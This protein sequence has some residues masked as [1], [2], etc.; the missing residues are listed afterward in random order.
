MYNRFK[1]EG[2]QVTLKMYVDIGT[3]NSTSFT[4]T[5]PI[6]TTVGP[7]VGFIDSY[8]GT[9]TPGMLI[10]NSGTTTINVYSDFGGIG[11]TASGSKG[12]QTGTISYEI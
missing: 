1:I 7:A 9:A 11:W 2:R 4:L 3:S 5:A 8:G 10:M 12:I 6:A